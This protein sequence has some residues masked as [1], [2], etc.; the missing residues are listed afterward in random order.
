MHTK[1]EEQLPGPAG[2]LMLVMDGSITHCLLLCATTDCCVAQEDMPQLGCKAGT[3]AGYHT[4][5]TS[6]C[7]VPAAGE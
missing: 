5:T 6:S 7:L 2:S 3:V 4:Q 1:H